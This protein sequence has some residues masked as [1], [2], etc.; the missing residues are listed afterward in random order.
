MIDKIKG[1]KKNGIVKVVFMPRRDYL[2]YFAKDDD[3]AYIGTEPQKQWTEEELEERFGQ[4]RKDL[5]SR[6][7]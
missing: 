1:V 6:Q 2:K 7:G 5:R 3:G 4:H